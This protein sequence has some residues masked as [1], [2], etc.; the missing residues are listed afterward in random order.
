MTE[1]KEGVG[2]EVLGI[3]RQSM[4]KL[5]TI[6]I[7]YMALGLFLLFGELPSKVFQRSL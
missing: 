4:V 5:F 1:Q 7:M 6:H 2:K 3:L